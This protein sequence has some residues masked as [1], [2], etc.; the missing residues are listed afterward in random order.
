[1]KFCKYLIVS[2]LAFNHAATV[3]APIELDRISVIVNNQSILK[4]DID[5]A[6]KL[7]KVNAQ[8][9]AQSL[10]ADSVLE[11]QVIDKLI[12][13]SLQ[14]QEADRIGV[15]IDDSRLN[16]ALE[17]I[18]KNNNQSI[19]Q[20]IASINDAGVSYEAYRDGIRNEVAAS[21]ARNAL[22]RRRINILPAE[23]DSLSDMLSQKTSAT[24]QYKISHI[25][26]R[27]ESEQDF[28][29][30]EALAKNILK[31]LDSGT[32]FETLALTYSK[33][34]KALNGGEWDWM[35]KEEMP[36]IFAD[37]IKV[38]GKNAIIGPFRSG[39]GVH[40]LKVKD[41]QGLE[42]VAVTEI[43]SRH[44]LIKPSIIL[45]DEGAQQELH[46]IRGDIMSGKSTFAQ[47][48]AQ[49]SQDPGSAA[50]QGELG[51]QTSSIFVPE[52]KHKIET[53]AVGKISEPFKTVHGWHIVEVLGHRQVDRTDSALKNKA[54]QILFN[55]KFNEESEAWIQELKASAFIEVVEGQE[56]D[57]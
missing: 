8:S 34:P 40:I 28:S 46:R 1:M 57:S 41:V 18:A 29:D 49:Y 7:V 13:D 9:E 32:S 39:V 27:P 36:T 17:N 35:R 42:T 50:K 24:T 15:K 26:L 12:S 3:A 25:L 37:Q 21:E 4:S 22:V 30:A 45:S 31:Q 47:M 43:N 2:L 11:Q 55:R 14:K 53:L 5:N 33:G 52:F 19:D 48:A 51:Y 56:D 6:I 54:Y 10:P 38:Q 20:L 44:I 23:V 16:L